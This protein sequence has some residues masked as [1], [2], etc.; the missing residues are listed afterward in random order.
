M[1]GAVGEIVANHPLFTDTYGFC[2]LSLLSEAMRQGD[3]DAMAVPIYERCNE[4]FV[5]QGLDGGVNGER[6]FKRMNSLTVT[7]KLEWSLQ[8]A[9]AV[10]VLNNNPGGV[11]VHDDI[12]LPQ[13]LLGQDGRLKLVRIHWRGC[14]ACVFRHGRLTLSITATASVTVLHLSRMTSTGQRSCCMT[15]RIT[16]TAGKND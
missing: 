5:R 16:N 14:A 11:I 7:E 4:T 9:E 6:P 15:K 2:A 10:A 3:V 13:F 12:Q 8:M 1:D